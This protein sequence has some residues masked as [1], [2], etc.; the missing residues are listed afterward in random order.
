[1]VRQHG[2]RQVFATLLAA[3]GVIEK[4]EKGGRVALILA[5]S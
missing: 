3:D 1:M 2:D 4:G 5:F